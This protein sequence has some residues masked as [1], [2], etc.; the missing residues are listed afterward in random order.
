MHGGSSS[1]DEPMAEMNLIPLIDI[2]LTLLIIM[3]V[4]TAFVRKPGVTLKLPE[5]V[6]HEG[7]PEMSK[8]QTISI[9]ENGTLYMD[10]KP[11]RDQDVQQRMKTVYQT[12]HEARVFIKGDRSVM[13][14]RVMA[15]MDIVRQAGLTKVVLPTDPKIG[16]VSPPSNALSPATSSPAT[17]PDSG[18][19]APSAPAGTNDSGALPPAAGDSAS[20]GTGAQ[21]GADIPSSAPGSSGS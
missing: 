6:T 4:T 19:G 7:S 18:G 14:S 8:D 13:Y 9:A 10:A 2:A 3:M 17:S 1:E 12:N 5:T 21:S 11:M 16:Q 20:P 15:V